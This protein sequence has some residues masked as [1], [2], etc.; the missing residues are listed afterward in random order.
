MLHDT[1]FLFPKEEKEEHN[2][3]TWIAWEFNAQGVVKNIILQFT[4][5]VSRGWN[6]LAT[7]NRIQTQ[8]LY[9]YKE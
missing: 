1:P 8:A 6:T 2:S 3:A 7:P 5:L 9:F 4:S